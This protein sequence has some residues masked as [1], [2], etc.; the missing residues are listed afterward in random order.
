[1]VV[2]VA[3]A[4]ERRGGEPFWQKIEDVIT[5]IFHYSTGPVLYATLHELKSY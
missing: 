4:V 2:V 5:K 1:V 3:V